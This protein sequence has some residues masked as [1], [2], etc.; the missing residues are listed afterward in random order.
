MAA[1]I[2]S[3][4]SSDLVSVDPI[5]KAIRATL[6]N[7]SGEEGTRELPINLSVSAVTVVNNDLI[8]SLDVTELKFI[9]LQLTGVWVGTVSFQGSNDNGD[10]YDIVSQDVASTTFPYSSSR[11]STGI[12]KIPIMYKYFRARV[13]QYTSG[14]V[15]GSAIG[16]KEDKSLSGVSQVGQVT[17]QAETT[18]VIGT[19]NVSNLEFTT[20]GLITAA[21][22]ALPAPSTSGGLLTGTPSVGSYLFLAL[23]AKDS[24]W[25]AEITGTLGGGTFYFEGSTSSTNGLNGNWFSLSAVQGGKIG[26]LLVGSTTTAGDFTGNNAGIKY[27]R[28]RAVSGVG[29][30]ASINIRSSSGTSSVFLKE[31]LPTGTNFIGKTAIVADPSETLLTDFYVTVA[32]AVNL[33]SRVIRNQACTLKAI[34]MTNYVATAR[35]VKIYDTSTTPVAGVGVPVIVLSLPASSTIAYP[36]PSSG[37]S[38]VN[39]VGMTMVLGA[40]NNNVTGSATDADVSLTS[41][42]T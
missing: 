11:S 23:E 3:G 25:S 37:L 15:T 27:F 28:V 40:A 13:T 39:G 18:K 16:H 34:V 33:N 35:H 31:S 42:F 22:T 1:E 24:T 6:Y 36:I 4:D 10:F 17:L 7:S 32:G 14:T 20:S 19:V 30:N 8:S 26:S 2:K 29:I 41:I 21:D 38:F 9:S 12:I 5:S